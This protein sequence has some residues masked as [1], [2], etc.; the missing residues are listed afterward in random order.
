MS[1][2][3]MSVIG[4][5]AFVTASCSR[6]TQPTSSVQSSAK[7]QEVEVRDDTKLLTL[8]GGS[9]VAQADMT[10]LVQFRDGKII[11]NDQIARKGEKIGSCTTGWVGWGEPKILSGMKD[12]IVFAEMYDDEI[13]LGLYGLSGA[14]WALIEC[15]L[16]T[17]D[18]AEM[19]YAQF[20]SITGNRFKLYQK[21]PA[22]K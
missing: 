1:S 17:G 7:K 2:F 15:H 19:T 3:K 22:T 16:A 18:S 21:A 12:G 10:L 6:G 11:S 5:L 8:G 13:R 20:K 14:N 4:C 9:I